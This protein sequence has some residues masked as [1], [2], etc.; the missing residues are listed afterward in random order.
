MLCEN[1]VSQAMLFGGEKPV[2]YLEQRS[3][4]HE[5]GMA[6]LTLGTEKTLL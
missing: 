4:E 2:P 5:K 6:A 3:S 1:G